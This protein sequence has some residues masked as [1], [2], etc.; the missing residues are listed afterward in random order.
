MPR[1]IITG[2]AGGIGMAVAR[3]LLRDTDHRVLL[4]DV[5]MERLVRARET[6]DSD[7]IDLATS[8]L[9]SQEACRAIVASCRDGADDLVH[10]AGVFEADAP[11]MADRDIWDRA[12][13]HNLTNA[14]DLVAAFAAQDRVE[15]LRHIVLASSSAYRRGGPDHVAYSASKGGIASMT[16]AL[17][18]RLAPHVLVNAVAPG[19]IATPMTEQL[20]A[21]SED[22]YRQQIPLGRFGRPEEVA[23]VVAFLCSPGA[24]YITG[25][26]INVDGG[27][28]NG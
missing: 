6:L 9:D 8:S 1:T 21:T 13:G 22:A 17:S 16:R 25:Q 12:I 14:Y 15:R 19:P 5:D 24:S 11:D 10:M 2:G 4:V 3:I 27:L 18:R 20:R 26:V 23:A 7:R 28:L